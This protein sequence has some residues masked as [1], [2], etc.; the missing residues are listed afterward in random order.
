MSRIYKSSH[1]LAKR[2]SRNDIYWWDDYDDFRPY[3]NHGP[4]VPDLTIF[5][6]DRAPVIHPTGLLGPDG[7]Q[8]VSVEEH[9]GMDFIGFIPPWELERITIETEKAEASRK[10]KGKT[11]AAS[12]K[13]KA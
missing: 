12:R 8:I 6:E 7:S 4:Y 2:E 9:P 13:R 10:T 1:E 3:Y 5:E 11:N